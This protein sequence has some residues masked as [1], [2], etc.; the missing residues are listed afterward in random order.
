MSGYTQD[1]RH[2]KIFTPL[3]T[4]VLLL[5]SLQGQEGVSQLFR[6]DLQ[7]HSEDHNIQFDEII[8]QWV[9]VSIDL[10]D[11]SIRFINGIICAFTQCGSSPLE[12]G[13]TPTVFSDYQAT[14]VPWL[15]M[16]TRSSNCRIFQHLTV[17][18]IITKIFKD[19]GFSDFSN[20]LYGNFEPREYCVQYR[21]TDFNFVSRLMEEE[22][23]FYYFEHTAEAHTLVFA[24]RSNEFKPSPLNPQVSYSSVIGLEPGIQAITEWRQSQEVQPG[25]YTLT[26]YN[27]EKPGFNLASTVT[28]T[29]ERGM[30]IYDY[31]GE[32]LEKGDGERLVGIRMEEEQ[33]FQIVTNGSST[34]RGFTPGSRFDL[35]DH[36]RRDFNQS[37]VLTSVHHTADQ[38]ANYR[39]SNEGAA[40]E[41]TYTNRFQCIPHATPFRPPRLTPVPIIHGTQTAVVVG[42]AGEE[43][44]PDQY[45]R[46]K[47]QFHWD[48][49]GAHNE[50]SSCW[51]RVSHPWAGKGWG[52]ISI[53]RIGQEVIVEFLE[54]NPDQPIITGRV[55]NARQM[56]PF[57]LPGSMTVSG[58][59]SNTHKGAGYNELSMD[60]TAGQEQ[61]TIHGQFD[62][63]TTVEHD[64]TT[65]VHN[66]RTDM[67]DQDD[68][69][70]VG[71]NQT[72]TVLKNRTIMV[73][74]THTEIIK[75]ATT[76]L[77]TEGPS[78][79][80]VM[81]GTHL[82]HVKQDVN[83]W[84]DANQQT[85]VVGNILTQALTGQISI[86]AQT[87][88]VLQCGESLLILKADG[89]ITLSGVKI[90]IS[91]DTE[92]KTGV[93]NQ[94]TVFNRSKVETSGAAINTSAVGM[95][96]ISGA[97]IKIN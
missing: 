54:G 23:I 90:N 94:N 63:N 74:G 62:M 30:E 21:E 16:L 60:D 37:Y 77:V 26:D 59:K 49:E 58:I 91:A 53:P 34:C 84:Y 4:D 86:G 46:V 17:P 5:R 78:V 71:G 9:T 69:E 56:P 10:P 12:N 72:H 8:G 89:T 35:L 15:W 25:Q 79:M 65:T 22:G 32:Y 42:P 44:Y 3:G 14:M 11:G 27:F 47:V 88:I 55:Y 20:R 93:G 82:H 81:A 40:A 73:N 92:V 70:T 45:G 66:N 31:P 80:D 7:L 39:S 41:F 6:F 24:N 52:A 13:Q 43:I 51:I 83:E 95:H 28:G 68:S 33:T 36:Y 96:E 97:L 85:V 48:R 18:E 64:Q 87:E 29:D 75:G 61:V 1:H 50:N 38:G 2:L 19:H 57:S 76:I 67:I